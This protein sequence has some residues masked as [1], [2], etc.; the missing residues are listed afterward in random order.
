MDLDESPRR[1]RGDEL[2]A[3]LLDAAW[4]ELEENG[5]AAFTYDGVA[6]RAETS[7]PVLYRRWPTRDELVLAAISR[8]LKARPR[9]ELADTGSLRG[10]LL[11][12]LKGASVRFGDMISLVSVLFGGYYSSTGETIGQIRARLIDSRWSAMDVLLDRA[13]ARGERVPKELPERVKTLPFDL[14]RHEFIMSLSQLGDEF[15]VSVV[16]EV[17]MP[18]VDDYARREEAT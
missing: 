5:Y 14:L 2:E 7:R 17:F 4:A 13:R 1:R 3:A 6:Q 11:S 15:I 12:M 9:V 10:D 8:H 18:L 16:D